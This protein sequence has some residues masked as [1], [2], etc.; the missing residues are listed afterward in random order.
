MN[1]FQKKSLYVALAGV[2]ALGAGAANAVSVNPDGL[3]QALIYPYYTVRDKVAGAP[4]QSLLSVVNSTASAKAV[5][6]RFL[7]GKNSRE[8]L[9]FNLYLSKHDVWTAAI[10]PTADGAGIFTKDTSCTSPTVSSSATSPTPFVNFAY[11][12]SGTTNTEDGADKSLDRTR[13]GYVEII[14]MGDIA[15]S[16]LEDAITHTTTKAGWMPPDCDA[17]PVTTTEAAGLFTRGSGG[18]FGSI[19]LINVAAGEDFALDAVALAD[20]S[21]APNGI[22][23]EP[24]SIL[25]NFTQ[26]SPKVSVVTSGNTTHVTEWNT[27]ASAL[28]VD[29]V[30]A[31]FMHDAIYNEFVLDAATK[32]ATDWVVTMPTKTF[33]YSGQITN[34]AGAVTGVRVV[35][36]FQRN[37]GVNGACD[38]VALT[39]FDREERE[40]EVTTNFSPPPPTAGTSICWEANI[41]TF[42]GASVLGSKN[43]SNLSAAQLQAFE[44]GWMRMI[45]PPPATGNAYHRLIGG[46]STIISTVGSAVSVTSAASTT[47]TGLPV[48]G[49]AAITFNNGTLTS[50]ASLVQSNYGGNLN[51]KATRSVVTGT[52]GTGN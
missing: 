5:K 50:G 11:T 21:D 4:Y 48:I 52:V 2:S 9:D 40:R 23:A 35:K 28:P 25:P 47:F 24:G 33:Y 32:S 41:V 31:V 43:T 44:N 34:A 22:W 38:D 51:H 12:F 20:F 15:D 6:V 49:F 42:R 1:T 16:D 27:P 7:E 45:F 3:G 8:V 26:V 39:I 30:S 14:E 29:P 37:F 46:A 17:V 18:L 19:T 10:I 36:L 13:E